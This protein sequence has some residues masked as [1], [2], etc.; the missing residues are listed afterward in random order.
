MILNM[1]NFYYIYVLLFGKD[2]NLYTGYT[3]NLKSRFERHT[4]GYVSST[5]GRRPLK[6]IYSE[7]CLDKKDAMHREK[8]LKT[9]HGKLFLKNRL[10][11][12]LTGCGF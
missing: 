7:A 9:Y 8:Y 2:K 12:Y 10:K 4:K 6:L 11:S 1:V 5:K 3:D